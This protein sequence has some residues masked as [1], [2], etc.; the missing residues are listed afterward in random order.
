MLVLDETPGVSVAVSN[1]RPTGMLALTQ[2]GNG[3]VSKGAVQDPP[4]GA[5]IEPIPLLAT[6]AS[7]RRQ[8]PRDAVRTAA[9][10]LRRRRHPCTAPSAR[11]MPLTVGPPTP[12]TP[13]HGSSWRGIPRRRSGGSRSPSIPTSTTR[14]SRS[15]WAT[16]SGSCP[17]VCA[18][19]SCTTSTAA[20]L[21]DSATTTRLAGP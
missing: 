2:K 1:D 6:R 8:E 17:T 14:W 5:G 11:P 19:R 15:S 12:M 9:E 18:T 21:A 13:S 7:A 16:P 20:S 4:E 3:A 10:L